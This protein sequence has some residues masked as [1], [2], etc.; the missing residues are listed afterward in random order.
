MKSKISL[1]LPYM[2]RIE[3]KIRFG[4]D[5]FVPKSV[6]H[7]VPGYS[8]YQN[9]YHVPYQRISYQKSVPRTKIRTSTCYTQQTKLNSKSRVSV[10]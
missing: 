6:P 8:P 2:D 1:N 10:L 7:T 4:T 9:P 3:K 5:Y